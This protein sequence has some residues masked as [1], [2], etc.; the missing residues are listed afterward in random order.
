[1]LRGKR[2]YLR[3][4]EEKDIPYKVK[5]I[6]DPVVR[7]TL[8]FSYP[9]SEVATKQWLSKV[10][11]DSSRKDFIVCL[12]E[13]DNPIGYGGFLNIDPKN[14]KAETYLGI[15]E[16]SY[17]G[18]GYGREAMQILLNYAFTE[19]GLNKVYSYSW[20]ENKGMINLN[21]SLGFKIEGKLEQDVFS[22]G[23]YRD[24]VVMGLLKKDY[25]AKQDGGH[26]IDP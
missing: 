13:N 15:G 24:R 22:H 9:I 16:I 18:Q 1:M 12:K 6:N 4:M 26:V 5:W 14:S 20:S 25:F 10:A 7:K 8:N 17:W 3:L 11:L 23:E 21:K 2:I 19:L